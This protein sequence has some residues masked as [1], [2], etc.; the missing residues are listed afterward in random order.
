MGQE[1]GRD[2]IACTI[3]IGMVHEGIYYVPF[4][5]SYE[6]PKTQREDAIEHA[7]EQWY[8]VMEE[9]GFM[10]LPSAGRGL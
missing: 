6:G 1:D 3:V 5:K 9:I 8:A 2:C 4:V 10:V 7:T